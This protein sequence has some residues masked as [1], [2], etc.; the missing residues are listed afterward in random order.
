M[1][2][3]LRID[4]DRRY[5]ATQLL[6]VFIHYLLGL[7]AVLC[8][9]KPKDPAGFFIASFSACAIVYF[10]I[11]FPRAI[12]LNNEVIVFMVSATHKKHIVRICDIVNVR[13]VA[14]FYNSVIIKTTNDKS[15]ILHPKDCQTFVKAI[16][17]DRK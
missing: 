8:F 2:N 15:Y 16:N 7:L 1:E 9:L 6:K 12:L 4:I 10:C 13:I 14:G 17:N 5:I 11:N 3:D